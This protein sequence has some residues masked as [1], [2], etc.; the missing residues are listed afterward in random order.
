MKS[1]FRNLIMS[2]KNNKH[3]KHLS[4]VNLVNM[5]ALLRLLYRCL[6]E[7]ETLEY[8]SLAN[9]GIH[10]YK[11]I[12]KLIMKNHVLRTLNIRGNVMNEDILLECWKSLH[13][14]IELTDIQYDSKD[15]AIDED[16]VESIRQELAMNRYIQT[17]IAV[18][19]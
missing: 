14:N 6:R 13:M 16:V 2:L 1:Y 11:Y 10:E 9:N 5:Q 18:H 8:L 3:L 15:K 19:I 7:N 17:D 12:N 4:F